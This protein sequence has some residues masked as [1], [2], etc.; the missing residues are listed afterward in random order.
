M[1]LAK[2]LSPPPPCWAS[3]RASVVDPTGTVVATNAGVPTTFRLDPG[4]IGVL[5]PTDDL[6]TRAKQSA[7]P[8]GVSF[9]TGPEH[10]A[11]PFS[12]QPVQPLRLRHS[13]RLGPLAVAG[14]AMRISDGGNADPVG[15]EERPADPDEVVITARGKRARVARPSCS[16]GRGAW[17]G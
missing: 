9:A 13:P 8:I 14:V 5:V 11:G 12:L 1:T 2:P 15:G 6:A 10:V 4:A 7:G 16:D 3:R 17:C